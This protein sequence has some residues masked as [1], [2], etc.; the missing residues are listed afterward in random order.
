MVVGSKKFLD[1]FKFFFIIL[2]SGNLL[3]IDVYICYFICELYLVCLND[4]FWKYDNNNNILFE[5]FV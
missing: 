2:K 1:N 3:W 4:V 5:F